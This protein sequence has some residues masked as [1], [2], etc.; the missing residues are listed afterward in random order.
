MVEFLEALGD[1]SRLKILALL[2]DRDASVEELAAALNLKTPTI[3][4]HLNRLRRA[5][6][7]DMRAEGTTHMYH[8]RAE[9]LHGLSRRLEPQKLKEWA[10]SADNAWEQKVLYDFLSGDKLKEIPASRKKRQVILKWLLGKFSPGTRYSEAEV[11]QTIGRHHPDFAT[12]RRELI[13]SRLMDRHDGVYW[14]I[15]G[16]D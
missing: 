9:T 2:I 1:E 10:P 6:L 15:D 12:L 11:N 8:F 3:S 7:V 14:R 13:A 5:D 16:S 4:H